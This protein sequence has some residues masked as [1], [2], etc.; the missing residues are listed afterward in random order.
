M[1][2]ASAGTIGLAGCGSDGDDGNGTE[3][4]SDGGDSGS[5]GGDGGT[6]TGDNGGD[7][8]D[9]GTDGGDNGGSDGGSG[10]IER[11]PQFEYDAGNTGYASA[12]SGPTSGSMSPNWEFTK[13]EEGQRE[14][15]TF[16]RPVVG[17]GLVVIAAGGVYSDAVSGG[18]VF[19]LDEAS[20][21]T[22]WT[23]ELNSQ[24]GSLA[25]L[26][27]TVYVATGE[28]LFAIDAASGTE[29]W[30]N[31]DITG[32]IQV[33]DGTIYGQISSDSNI[34]PDSVGMA[35]VSA[36]DGSTK[37]TKDIRNNHLAAGENALVVMKDSDAKVAGY[38]TATGEK[39]YT[40]ELGD[41]NEVFFNPLSVSDGMAYVPGRSGTLYALDAQ[42]GSA[43][44]TKEVFDGYQDTRKN[45]GLPTIGEDSIFVGGDQSIYGLSKADG[46]EMWSTPINMPDGDGNSV[47]H[48]GDTVLYD[49][50][51]AI[52]A[53]NPADGSE[54][55]RWEPPRS[56]E[57]FQKGVYANGA[58]YAGMN[59]EI[60]VKFEP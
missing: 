53:L 20:E 23:F 27:G 28:K 48:D 21:T 18:T 35:A 9:G 51:E 8:G 26:D 36:S 16:V 12:V 47:V 52:M 25:L 40:K 34:G 38:D 44:W 22:Q 6:D 19:A 4:G 15:G 30:T 56:N 7:G 37:W 14:P 41:G 45:L 11:W 39:L 29:Q 13:G 10:P 1:S 31:T 60:L 2:L 57:G 24:A 50:R 55:W 58:F 3:S 46:S 17:D 33:R 32:S 49:K 5:D 42:S 59:N 54:K 43:V